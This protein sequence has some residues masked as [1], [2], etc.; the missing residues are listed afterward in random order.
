MKDVE[1]AHLQP[2]VAGAATVC[3]RGCNRTAHPSGRPSN[4]AVV[5]RI[6]ATQYPIVIRGVMLTCA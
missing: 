3:G 6:A 2:Y 4:L 5:L 1:A